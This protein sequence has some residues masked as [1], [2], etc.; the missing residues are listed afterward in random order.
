MNN[1]WHPIGSITTGSGA[2]AIVFTSDGT[3]AYITNQGASNV[4]V[5]NVNNHS[6]TIDIPVGTKPNGLLIRYVN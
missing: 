4:S 3:K 5:I 6:K 1:E 2:H